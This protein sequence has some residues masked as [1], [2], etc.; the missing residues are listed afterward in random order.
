MP[1]KDGTGPEGKGPRTGR[2]FGNCQ[3]ATQKERGFGPC[4]RGMGKGKRRA[5]NR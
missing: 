2:G 1:N 3:G 5:F 4:G